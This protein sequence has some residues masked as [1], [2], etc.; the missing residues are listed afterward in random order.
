MCIIIVNKSGTL[1]RDILTESALNNPD[2]SGL[3]YSDG[4]KLH[5]FKSMQPEETINKYYELRGRGNTL[6]IVLHFRITTD[7]LSNI[8]NCHPYTISTNVGLAHNGIITEYSGWM[9]AKSDTALFI[10]HILRAFSDKVLISEEMNNLLSMAVR[11]WNKFAIMNNH[12]VIS[13]VN[14][15]F[16]IWDKQRLNWFSNDTYKVPKFYYELPKR[17]KYDKGAYNK[18]NN[19]AVIANGKHSNAFEIC[20]WCTK[21]YLCTDDELLNGVCEECSKPFPTETD[22]PEEYCAQCGML[23]ITKNE[24]RNLLCNYCYSYY[25]DKV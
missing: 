6:P 24:K 5:I 7:G 14:S 9:G 15:E 4:M 10:E 22:E 18:G 23:L 17:R 13:I 21:H 8:D 11:K 16:G 19:T 12:G 3:M 20:P 2:G 1:K 25:Y